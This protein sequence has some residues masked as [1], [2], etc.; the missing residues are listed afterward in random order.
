MKV[1]ASF[2]VHGS[3]CLNNRKQIRFWEDKW[4]DIF[5][6]QHQYPSLYNIVRRK[7]ATVESVLSTMLLNVSFC[8]FLNQNNLVLWND[9]VGRVMHMRLNDHADVFE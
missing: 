3:F 7:N 9:L 1:K 8:R 4:L 2:L 5:S 6:F